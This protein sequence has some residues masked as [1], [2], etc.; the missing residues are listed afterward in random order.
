MTLDQ[1]H[2]LYLIKSVTFTMASIETAVDRR[3]AP[4]GSRR[5]P[6]PDADLATPAELNAKSEAAGIAPA[7]HTRDE[8]TT[9]TRLS[10]PPRT[11]SA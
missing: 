6:A 4:A 10:E 9:E 2:S 1:G 11:T 5:G 3:A 7:A 8:R